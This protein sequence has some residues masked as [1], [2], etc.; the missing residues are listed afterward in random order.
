MAQSKMYHFI[1]KH[2]VVNQT[3]QT[4]VNGKQQEEA[5]RLSLYRRHFQAR[6]DRSAS[7]GVSVLF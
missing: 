1:P 3:S 5:S 7:L 6:A 4:R 2:K